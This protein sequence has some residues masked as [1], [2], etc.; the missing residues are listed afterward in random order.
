VWESAAP[1]PGQRLL[2]GGPGCANLHR[3][4]TPTLRWDQVLAWR[5]LASTWSVPQ[6]RVPSRCCAAS[7]GCRLRSRRR[8]RWRLESAFARPGPERLATALEDR[9][10]IKTSAM[11]GTLHLLP[12]DAAGAYL[13]LIAAAR[14]WAPPSWQRTFIST[15]QLSALIEAVRDV[16]DGRMSSSRSRGRGCCA[17]GRERA[18][19]VLHQP[20]DVGAGLARHPRRARGRP[21]RAPRLSRRVWAGDHGGVRR[22][23]DARRVE[24][25][26]PERLARGRR[27]S[28]GRSRRRRT[29]ASTTRRP[30]ERGPPSSTKPASTSLSMNEA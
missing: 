25:G 12:A 2:M 5:W 18:T 3:M 9:T 30:S 6:T 16:L 26:V 20:G 29:T 17:T 7:A 24:P 27:G 21:H 22:V 4:G 23:V 28:S 8:Q 14:T 10:V 11:R 1:R 19:R 13:A 15:A